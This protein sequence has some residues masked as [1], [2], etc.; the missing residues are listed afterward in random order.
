MPSR[1][2]IHCIFLCLL[3][4][5]PLGS[6]C[7]PTSSNVED[8]NRKQELYIGIGAEPAALD[9]H[10]TTGLTEYSVMLALFE[11][12]TTLH[13]ETMVVQPGVAKSWDI[14]DDGLTYR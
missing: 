8:G 14:S 1:Q 4:M 3:S 7:T 6:G 11:G 12:L 9:P 10:I 13:P 5:L 2:R